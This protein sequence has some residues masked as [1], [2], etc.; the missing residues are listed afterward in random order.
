[1]NTPVFANYARYYDLLYR[2][3]DYAGE[4]NFVHELIQTHIPTATTILDLGCG[5]GVH[6]SLLAAKGYAVHGVDLSTTMLEAAQSRLSTLPPSQATKLQF[7][8]GN[9]QT[10]RVNQTFDVVT[11][12]FHVV[13]YQ[14]TN[15]A[16]QATFATA[17][18]HLNPGGI[19]LFDCW[20]GPAVLTDPPVVRVKRL[21]DDKI[22]VTRIAEPVVHFNQNVVD[23]NYQVLIRDRNTAAVEELHEVHAMRYLFK[24]E[25]DLLFSQYGFTPLAMGEWMTCQA[26]GRETWNVYFIGKL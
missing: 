2:D 22:Q 15:E 6:A 14:T 9:V 11:S 17:K 4:A 12:L 26:P 19:F 13:S 24:P 23:V 3:K 16:L 8:Q 18:T 7:S 10:I 20:Y 5:T 21:E 1:M 25:V